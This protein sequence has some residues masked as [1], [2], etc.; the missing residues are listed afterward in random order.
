MAKKV[1][2]ALDQ[3]F[4]DIKPKLQEIKNLYVLKDR[5]V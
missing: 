1:A 2:K 4:I 5:E 3:E